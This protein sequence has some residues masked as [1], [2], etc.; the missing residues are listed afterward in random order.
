MSFA[1]TLVGAAGMFVRASRVLVSLF[2]LAFAMAIGSASVGFRGIFVMLSGFIMRF[3]WHGFNSV[4]NMS[5][6]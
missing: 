6:I 2:I 5:L 3:S 1:S 4:G